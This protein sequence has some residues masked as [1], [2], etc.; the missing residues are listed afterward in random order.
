MMAGVFLWI[1]ECVNGLM[2]KGVRM[3]WLPRDFFKDI[4]L[5]SIYYI[6]SH[7][8]ASSPWLACDMISDT[9]HGLPCTYIIIITY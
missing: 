6:L 3:G 9:T 7:F 4:L 2:D 5:V 8:Y 1:Y